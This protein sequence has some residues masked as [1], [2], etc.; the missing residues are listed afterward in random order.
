MKNNFKLIILSAGLL[1]MSATGCK[2]GYFDINSPNPN[3]PSEVPPK[4]IL[5]LPI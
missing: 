1:A 3:T 5:S 2:K 4:F